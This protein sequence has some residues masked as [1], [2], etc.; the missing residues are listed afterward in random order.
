MSA[1]TL[2]ARVTFPVLTL[3]P[4]MEIAQVQK[5]MPLCTSCGDVR[6][7]GEERGKRDMWGRNRGHTTYV[8]LIRILLVTQGNHFRGICKLLTHHK[9][10]P[11]HLWLSTMLHY[12]N[13]Q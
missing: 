6:Q 7:L 2:M 9:E 1:E 3:R 12:S 11:Y 4:E 5:A 10:N 8:Q 13:L